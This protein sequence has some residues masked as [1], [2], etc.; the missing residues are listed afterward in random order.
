MELRKVACHPLLVRSI[1]T[2]TKLKQLAAGI[3]NEVGIAV[4]LLYIVYP[5]LL[6]CMSLPFFSEKVPGTSTHCLLI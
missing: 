3:Y 6:R 5:E 4:A 2:D 1:Y